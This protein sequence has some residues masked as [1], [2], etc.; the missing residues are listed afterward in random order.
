MVGSRRE[1]AGDIHFEGLGACAEAQEGEGAGEG[2]AGVVNRFW[3]DVQ[4]EDSTGMD[5]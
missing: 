4:R 1:Y 2:H 5:F 3:W